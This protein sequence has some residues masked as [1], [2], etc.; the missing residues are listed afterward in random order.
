MPALHEVVCRRVWS[1]GRI[2]LQ[3]PRFN[4]PRCH[5]ACNLGAGR[6]DHIRIVRVLPH[7]QFFDEVEQIGPLDA[8]PV[9]IDR[10]VR[11]PIGRIA[12]RVIHQRR[13]QHRAASRQW[14]PRPP[15][16]ERAGMPMPNGLLPCRLGIDGHQWQADFDELLAV[17]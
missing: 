17:G 4:Q 15:Q 8:G 9:F 16:M 10:P 7:H 11:L 6:P 1:D 3:C 13:E 5:A 2:L 12:V 14:P